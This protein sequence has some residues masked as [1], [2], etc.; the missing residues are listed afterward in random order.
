MK[1]MKEYKCMMKVDGQ[2]Y[3]A[4]SN[5]WRPSLTNSYEE[6]VKRLNQVK[7]MR[8]RNG[9]P[10]QDYKLAVREVTAWEDVTDGPEMATE[11]GEMQEVQA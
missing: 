4:G 3:R 5:M 6:A 11:W 9:H 8:A 1:M 10:A 2:W 7:E